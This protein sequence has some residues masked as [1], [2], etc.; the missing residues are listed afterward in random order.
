[1]RNHKKLEKRGYHIPRLFL[2]FFDRANPESYKQ[3]RKPFDD[4]EL[5]LHCQ[6]LVPYATSSWMLMANFNWLYDIFDDFIIMILN[7]V[8]YLQCHRNITAAHHALESAI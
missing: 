3:T 4:N 7:Y 1:M 2:E 6:T 5:N 8:G